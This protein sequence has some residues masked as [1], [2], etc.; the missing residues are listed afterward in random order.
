M[1]IILDLYFGCFHFITYYIRL[2]QYFNRILMAKNFTVTLE[3][4][5]YDI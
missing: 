2:M 5:G 4:Y 1:N 3:C